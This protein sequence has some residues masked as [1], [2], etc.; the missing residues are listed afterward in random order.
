[1][2][3]AEQEA[4][5]LTRMGRQQN[6]L[7]AYFEARSQRR[8]DS[9]LLILKAVAMTAVAVLVAYLAVRT[10]LH[11]TGIGASKTVVIGANSFRTITHAISIVP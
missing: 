11:F 7:A 1:L 8:R 6:D 4:C 2:G 9:A 3:A 5:R 10:F